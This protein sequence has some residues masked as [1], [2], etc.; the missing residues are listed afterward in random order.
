MQKQQQIAGFTDNLLV[1]PAIFKHF[2]SGTGT[3]PENVMV[4]PE[5]V[6]EQNCWYVAGSW[7]LVAGS[8]LPLVQ[9]ISSTGASAPL[10]FTHFGIYI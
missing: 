6:P 4:K 5:L 10:K 3:S 2:S 7:Y 8:G 9:G 1:K